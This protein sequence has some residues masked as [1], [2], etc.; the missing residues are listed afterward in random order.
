MAQPKD[1]TISVD[2]L[3]EVAYALREE[4]EAT[5]VKQEANRNILRNL[6]TS[7]MLSKERSE[8]LAEI[9]PVRTRSRGEASDEAAE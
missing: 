9:Y 7:G 1:G 6:D 8:E 3:F 5:L 4:R 2:D